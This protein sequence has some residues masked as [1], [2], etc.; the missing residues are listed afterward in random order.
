MNINFRAYSFLS[1]KIF[2]LCVIYIYQHFFP[3]VGTETMEIVHIMLQ[4]LIEMCVANIDNQEVIYDSRV[5]MDVLNGILQIR[6][7]NNKKRVVD[8]DI[9]DVSEYCQYI[10]IYSS[11]IC[12]T[13]EY[14]L[15]K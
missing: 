13:S 8:Y 3:D 4:T 9:K 11:V 14:Y 10:Y 12:S 5:I 15:C 2:S 7:Y 6:L 1:D